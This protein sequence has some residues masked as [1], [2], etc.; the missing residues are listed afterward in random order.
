MSYQFYLILK[1][2]LHYG[3]TDLPCQKTT[4]YT[5]THLTTLCCLRAE[6]LHTTFKPK[7]WF[8]KS[9]N[10]TK[11]IQP[12]AN[13]DLQTLRLVI[14]AKTRFVRA[15]PTAIRAPCAGSI[16]PLIGCSPIA[17]ADPV[18]KQ[19]M[20]QLVI[21]YNTSPGTSGIFSWIWSYTPPD[22]ITM[23]TCCLETMGQLSNSLI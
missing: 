1:R 19:P 7:R 18:C 15:S 16:N 4:E 17:V 5:Y 9:Q 13:V 3:D 12:L 20:T 6:L 21:S 10:V 14:W 23:V 22:T 2:S 11:T 8:I